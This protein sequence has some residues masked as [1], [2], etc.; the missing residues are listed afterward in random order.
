ML[1]ILLL[2][3]KFKPSHLYKQSDFL[4]KQINIE[5]NIVKLHLIWQQHGENEAV[6]DKKKKKDNWY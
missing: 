4:D 2:L 3:Q 5:A 1:F 6:S